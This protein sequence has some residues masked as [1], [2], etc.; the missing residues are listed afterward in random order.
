MKPY[1]VWDYDVLQIVDIQIHIQ[2][3]PTKTFASREPSRSSQ[4][5]SYPREI[6]SSFSVVD[7][8]NKAE[9]AI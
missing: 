6:C 7:V 5:P 1:T 9:S 4:H 3:G 8:V 2:T